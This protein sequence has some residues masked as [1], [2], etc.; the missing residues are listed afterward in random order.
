M[1]IN[2]RMLNNEK[3]DGIMGYMHLG[4]YLKPKE[5]EKLKNMLEEYTKVFKY[6]P[7]PRAKDIYLMGIR[8]Y[9]EQI[10]KAKELQVRTG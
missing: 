1:F 2:Y 9:E 3:G 7:K 4:I 6:L 10:K 8:A 5:A